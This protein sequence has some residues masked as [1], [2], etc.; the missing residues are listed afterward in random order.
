ME[1]FCNSLDALQL[2][3]G[4]VSMALHGVSVLQP[5]LMLLP[6]TD[7]EFKITDQNMPSDM[8]PSLYAAPRHLGT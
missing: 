6:V 1:S 5:A 3:E 8:M 4:R 7:T 2:L